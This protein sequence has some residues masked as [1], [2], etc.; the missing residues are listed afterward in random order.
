MMRRVLNLGLGILL[1]P[2]ALPL[3]GLISVLVCLDSRG[4]AMF[5]QERVGRQGH[6]YRIYKFRTKQWNA[7]AWAQPA[8]TCAMETGATSFRGGVRV[9]RRPFQDSQVTRMGRILRETGLDGLPQILNVLTG[10]VNLVGPSRQAPGEVDTC[11]VVH[12][13]A[14]QLAGDGTSGSGGC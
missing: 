11:T 10:D 4:P 14:E 7:G 5:L 13:S 2:F 6:P 1:L 12:G 9:V 8:P 3:M